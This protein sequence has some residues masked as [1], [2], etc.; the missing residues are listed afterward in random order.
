MGALRFKSEGELATQEIRGLPGVVA[1]ASYSQALRIGRGDSLQDGTST[2]RL[3][4]DAGYQ[5][6][7]L[8]DAQSP[9]HSNWKFQYLTSTLMLRTIFAGKGETNFFYSFGASGNYL[10]KGMQVLGFT[11]YDLKE[12]LMKHNIN[13]VAQLGIDFP[14]PDDSHSTLAISYHRGLSNLEKDP[15][16]KARLHSLQITATIYFKKIT[17]RK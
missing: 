9:I 15:E 1:Q 6:I 2:H 5:S 16:Q 12:D 17:F 7:R 14:L 10:L 3:V 11:R 4:F 8:N 13:A